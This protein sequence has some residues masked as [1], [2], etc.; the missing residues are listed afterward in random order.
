LIQSRAAGKEGV[1]LGRSAIIVQRAEQR[2][3][4]NHV[5]RVGQ[6][7]LGRQLKFTTDDN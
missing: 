7:A 1:R 3:G 2:I 6:E 5:G 4:V